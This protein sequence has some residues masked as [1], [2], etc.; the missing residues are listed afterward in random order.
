MVEI[1][2]YNIV[3][4][5]LLDN[6]QFGVLG[7]LENGA[8][9]RLFVDDPKNVKGVL[10]YFPA[11]RELSLFSKE[12]TFLDE[13]YQKFMKGKECWFS[14]ISL[15]IADYYK[16]LCGITVHPACTA[17]YYTGGQF[18][19][20]PLPEGFKLDKIKPSYYGCVV[21]HHQYFG[22]LAEVRQCA[23]KFPTVAAYEGDKM[24][25]WCLIHE[26]GSLGPLFTLPDYRGKGLGVIVTCEII[27]QMLKLGMR[28]YS[29]VV[30]GNTHSERISPHTSFKNAEMDICWAH[31]DNNL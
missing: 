13:V 2:D 31:K 10:C 4:D 7:F 29:Y 3:K 27:K 6:K 26:N 9:L 25:C 24:V 28:P 23:R 18:N 22:S 8:K 11:Y 20:P 16:E 19:A 15:D 12:K 1:K 30:K 5:F 17:F 14:C 21:E